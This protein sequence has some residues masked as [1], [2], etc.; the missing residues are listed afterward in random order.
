M[1]IFNHYLLEIKKKILN[2]PDFKKI[3]KKNL[4]NVIVESPPE[5]YN[6]DLST[7]IALILSKIIK[8]D[9]RDIAVKIKT[10]LINKIND[11]AEIEIAG[12]GFLNIRLS[13]TAWIKNINSSLKEKKNF[14]SDKNK[15]KYN[16]EFVSANPTGPLHVGHCRGAVF[17]DV[18]SNLLT[19]NGNNVTKEFYVNDYGNQIDIFSESVFYRLRE[20]KFHENFP[21]N[22]NLYPG[23]YILD[24]A[25][26][27]LKKNPKLDLS[28]FKKI[29][30]KLGKISI[31]Y[32]M[33]LIKNDLK[34]LGIKH[35]KFF[36]ESKIVRENLIKKVL[37]KLKKDKLV[38]EGFLKPPKGEEKVDWKK[39]KKL[40]FKS[41]LFNDDTDRSLQKDDG[42]WT[43]F[44]ND[45]AYH[46]NKISR[47]Y[48]FLIN[49]L[50]ADHIGYTKRIVAAVK[51]ISKN[52]TQLI[53]KVCQ[54]VKLFKKGQ[55]FKMSKRQGDFISVS[56]L[57]KEVNKDSIRFMMLNRG[58]DMEIDFDF[59]K[60]LEKNKDNQVF[61]VQYCYARI[62][63]LFR[64][65]N[66][67]PEKEIK[68]DKNNFEPNTFEYKLLRK[69][70]EWPKV[71]NISS[72]R[73]EPHRITFYLYD[74]AT[75]FHSYWSEGNKSENYKFISNN[76]MNNILSFKI[77]QLISVVLQ[78]AMRILGVSLPKKM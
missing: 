75:I 19:F 50:G 16:I 14:G 25:K 4:N 45:L 59:E 37:N 33:D 66:L 65:L 64:N 10:I 41:T 48:D 42:T 44:A 69:I 51:A 18:I 2:S 30:N 36:F 53:C 28:N 54:L 70:N 21:L 32:S 58:N 9:S 73:L 5:K 77:F 31:N 47:K 71:I 62:N 52:K 68:I 61:Y 56:D 6:F 26:K 3:K 17:G 49:I 12:P 20:I 43:Y 22:K 55:P 29:K 8:T 38:V 39:T 35:D 24:I 11:F 40:I 15:K 60:V 74:L 72:N 63:S 23:S 13:K 78:N 7:N 27:I 57:L 67:D 46:S 76:K 34:L 1:N